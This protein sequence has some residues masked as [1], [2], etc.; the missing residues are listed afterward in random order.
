MEAE[1]IINKLETPVDRL[2]KGYDTTKYV[3]KVVEPFSSEYVNTVEVFKDHFS[4]E[5]KELWDILNNPK[6][7][8][9]KDIFDKTTHL[10]SFLNYLRD[11]IKDYASYS[12]DQDDYL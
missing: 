1:E 10:I 12:D 11:E 7:K 3:K 9:H 5:T 2:G 6:G 4:K 8:T